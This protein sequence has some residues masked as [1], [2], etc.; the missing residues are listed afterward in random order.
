MDNT[1]QSIVRQHEANPRCQ[2]T[3][4]RLL[5]AQAQAGDTKAGRRL[6]LLTGSSPRFQSLLQVT[7]KWAQWAQLARAIAFGDS[8]V[9]ISI[10]GG[11]SHYCD[12]RANVPYSQ[13]VEWEIGFERGILP[14]EIAAPLDWESPAADWSIAG[15][16]PTEKVQALFDYLFVEYGEPHLM[17]EE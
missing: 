10:Q 5:R 4:Q 14:T 17:G 8:G 2:Q 1:I 3:L 7:G 11:G 13:Y 6:R 9:S 15:Y 12:P 16:V